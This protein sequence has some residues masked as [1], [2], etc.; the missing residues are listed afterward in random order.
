LD[1]V[2][3]AAC[4]AKAIPIVAALLEKQITV[5][6]QPKMVVEV[7]GIFDKTAHDGFKRLWGRCGLA[8]IDFWQL[9]WRGTATDWEMCMTKS[10][11]AGASI[12]LEEST[13]I[14]QVNQTAF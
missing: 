11:K 12:H 13:I 7:A 10:C 6:G 4:T 8:K 9:L 14:Q 5:V 1:V 3:A 2:A